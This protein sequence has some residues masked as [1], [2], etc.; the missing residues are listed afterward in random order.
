MLGAWKPIKDAGIMVSRN[1]RIED[2][3]CP[4]N[5]CQDKDILDHPQAGIMFFETAL[6]AAYEVFKSHNPPETKIIKAF[7]CKDNELAISGKNDTVF[8]NGTAMVLSYDVNIEED[9]LAE[10]KDAMEASF[11]KVE[12]DEE[13]KTFTVSMEG[14]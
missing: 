2:L 1:L 10:L 6:I 14:L 13:S 5:L 7:S 8:S 4:C 9:E 3:M 11:I 12:H